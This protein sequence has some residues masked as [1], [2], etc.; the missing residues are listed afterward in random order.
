MESSYSRDAQELALEHGAPEVSMTEL[1]QRSTL[2]N[3][4]Q[5]ANIEADICEDIAQT[6]ELI[7]LNALCIASG[8]LSINKIAN[9]CFLTDDEAEVCYFS[10]DVCIWVWNNFHCLCCN[11]LEHCKRAQTIV[12]VQLYWLITRSLIG[13]N[14]IL[15]THICLDKAYTI[16]F[17]CDNAVD[18]VP[19]RLHS[20]G[21]NAG[22]PEIVHG[23]LQLVY[24]NDALNLPWPRVDVWDFRLEMLA[25]CHLLCDDNSAGPAL[26][27]AA[28]TTHREMH[29]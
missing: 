22:F 9:L 4:L 10:M 5:D 11:A 19:L 26:V 25:N 16:S 7:N 13:S 14:D 28:S 21:R 12:V 3:I 24:Y 8:L 27:S 23:I 20:R 15:I 1:C 2:L 29:E 18:E 6:C 17:R